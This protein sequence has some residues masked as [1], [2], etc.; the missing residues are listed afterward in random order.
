[1]DISSLIYTSGKQ[2][3]SY[4]GIKIEL[5]GCSDK[6]FNTLNIKNDDTSILNYWK[7]IIRDKQI[8]SILSEALLTDE[9]TDCSQSNL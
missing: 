7:S 8:D 9:I 1:M 3:D 5:T 6:L 2:Y 4:S